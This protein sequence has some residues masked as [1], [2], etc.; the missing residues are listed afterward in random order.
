MEYLTVRSL[1]RIE[2]W[3]IAIAVLLAITLFCDIVHAEFAVD[4]TY[5][6]ID[7]AWAEVETIE[8]K[9]YWTEIDPC[10]Q[11]K[12]AADSLSKICQHYADSARALNDLVFAEHQGHL[13]KLIGDGRSWWQQLLVSYPILD[14]SEYHCITCGNNFKTYRSSGYLIGFDIYNCGEHLYKVPEGWEPK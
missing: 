6:K 9:V 8:I 3:L 5:G 10:A 2:L 4:S 12:A 11:V 7:T 14:P 13:Y 1:H